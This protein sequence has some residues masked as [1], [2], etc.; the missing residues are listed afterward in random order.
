MSASTISEPRSGTPAVEARDRYELLR[1]LGSVALTPPPGN[2]P[3]WRALDLDPATG[4]EHTEVFVLGLPPHAAIYLGEEGKLGGEGLDRVGGFWRALGMKA[5]EDAD[6]LGA[7]LMLY[8]ELGLAES[9]ARDADDPRTVEQLRTS[10]EA[11]LHEH[12]WSWVPAYLRAVA[13]LQV[14][15][16]AEWAALTMAAVEHEQARTTSAPLLPLALR[17]APRGLTAED[18]VDDLLDALVAPVRSGVVLSQRDLQA[19]AA[20]V[21][22]GFR[23]GERRFALRA[24]LEQDAPATLG[25]LTERARSWAGI[26]RAHGD[27]PTTAWWCARA[28]STATVLAAALEGEQ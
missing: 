2:E 6:H 3:V 7:L 21:G 11:L 14:P 26:H 18:S 1:A 8:A 27:D 15:S 12:L 20:I 10:R 17:E 19:G 4:A 25:W 9:L 24:M 23:R 5:P 22:V 28:E 13:D 16:L